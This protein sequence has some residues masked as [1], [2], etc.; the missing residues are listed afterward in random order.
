[1]TPQKARNAAYLLALAIPAALMGGALVSQYVFG[2]FPCEMCWWQR[3]P[4]IAAIVLA[5]LALSMKGRGSGDLAVT[6]AALCIGA[7]GLIGG[8][9]A[10]VEYGWWEGV[11]ACATVAG[12]G[13]PLD[14]IMNAPVI[15]C[16]VAP[17][18]LLGISLAGF[19]FLISTAGAVLVLAL[20]GKSRR[21]A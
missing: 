7:S 3:Y 1:M 5:L 14:A 19:N 16:D 12:G 11:T 13:D 8:F 15:R 4:H 10:G 20:L 6:L 18:T 17:W 9:H 2:L 21:S